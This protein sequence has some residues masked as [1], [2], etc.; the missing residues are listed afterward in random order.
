M[1]SVGS[2][3]GCKGATRDVGI[4]D[5]YTAFTAGHC[6]KIVP[7]ASSGLSTTLYYIIELEYCTAVPA[8]SLCTHSTVHVHVFIVFLFEWSYHS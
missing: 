6:T 8:R 5:N 7:G 4:P 2:F 1:V 3:L